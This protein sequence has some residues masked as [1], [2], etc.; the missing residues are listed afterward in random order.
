MTTND[1]R[2]EFREYFDKTLK[3]KKPTIGGLDREIC[4]N[5]IANLLKERDLSLIAE[6]EDALRSCK[7]LI[8]IQNEPQSN[9]Y[10][11]LKAHTLSIISNLRE[12]IQ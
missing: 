8:R 9:Q 7:N 3:P 10:S 11:H 5:F 4:I 1:W 12:R 2:E 6:L